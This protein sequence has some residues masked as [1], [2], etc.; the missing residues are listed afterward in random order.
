MVTEKTETASLKI[1]GTAL[2]SVFKD[3]YD[4]IW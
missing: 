1:N 3:S 4:G 2:Y